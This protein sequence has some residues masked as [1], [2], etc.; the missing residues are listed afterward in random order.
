MTM[1]YA[2][3]RVLLTKAKDAIDGKDHRRTLYYAGRD[4]VLGF[5]CDHWDDRKHAKLFNDKRTAG[6]YARKLGGKVVEIRV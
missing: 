6:T 1:K 3:S 2:I 5:G 4:D